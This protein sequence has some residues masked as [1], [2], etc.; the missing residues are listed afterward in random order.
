MDSGKKRIFR[1]VS[2]LVALV[3][4]VAGFALIALMP[5]LKITDG[6]SL[7]LQYFIG[8]VIPLLS[9][10]SDL[11]AL[12]AGFFPMFVVLT[13]GVTYIFGLIY[14]IKLIV[15]LFSKKEDADR[16]IRF[17][18]A[19]LSFVLLGFFAFLSF[20]M[21][22]KNDPTDEIRLGL[23]SFLALG[24]GGVGALASACGYFMTSEKPVVNKVLR[25]CLMAVSFAA[26][27]LVF[28]QI[29]VVEGQLM[30]P[31]HL[32]LIMGVNS[33]NGGTPSMNLVMIATGLS[34]ALII[35]FAFMNSVGVT[36]LETRKE[37]VE[38]AVKAHNITMIV[39]SAIAVILTAAVI[40][41]GPIVVKDP[42]VL[43]ADPLHAYLALGAVVLALVLAILVVA[44]PEKAVQ[45]GVTYEPSEEPVEEVEEPVEEPVQEEKPIEEK[46][47]VAEAVI[48]ADAVSE[49]P[50]EEVKV[51]EAKEE[52]KEEEKPQEV[53]PKEE[54]PAPAKKA[55][56][57]EK[58][59]AKE[60]KKEAPKKEAA[61]KKAEAKKEPAKK[62]EAPKKVEE[63]K[64]PAKKATPKKTE[65]KKEK[66]AKEPEEKKDTPKKNTASYHVSK[67]AS[68][69]KWQVFRAGSD[70]VIKLFDTKV[71]AEE[72]TK[73]MAENQGVSYL[74][75]ASKGKNKGRIQKK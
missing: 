24:L 57:K 63:K 1:I 29:F 9:G 25:M 53:A 70:K 18:T 32:V 54:K 58:A 56:K 40:F 66:A 51:E 65:E 31:F 27:I 37:K 30:S 33:F 44:V 50:V 45:E 55:A 5:V 38:K 64:T 49:E 62:E 10:P 19:S 14:I 43:A 15:N 52:P 48:I 73:R 71:E 67:R 26:A 69:N 34:T 61:P 12:K 2:G 17:D 42:E 59:P 39:L 28:M 75:H 74:S 60:E 41:V 36:A 16:K 11:D 8:K 68:D 46:A 20:I 21:L 3:A 72:Y 7:T 23:G 35:A 4:V 13:Y 22:Q 47:E 6:D